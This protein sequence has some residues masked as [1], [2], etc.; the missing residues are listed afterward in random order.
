M[1]ARSTSSSASYSGSRP[2]SNSV[3]GNNNS[4]QQ[5]GFSQ[6]SNSALTPTQQRLL[7]R[8]KEVQ[9]FA[10]LDG[11]AAGFAEE[12][13]R[14]SQQTDLLA[15]G[16]QGGFDFEDATEGEG[17]RAQELEQLMPLAVLYSRCGCFAEL[18]RSIQ[19]NFHGFM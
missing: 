9:L 10:A 16:S 4:Q 2:G 5:Y 3:S 11:Q 12:L 7:A 18:A 8:V 13:E 17:R 1:S 19:N 6:N 14:L 15:D